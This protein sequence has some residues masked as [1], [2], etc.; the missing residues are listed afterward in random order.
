MKKQYKKLI[1][2]NNLLVILDFIKFCF[3]FIINY[4]ST[5]YLENKKLFVILFQ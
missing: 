1:Y 4:I 3:L 2:D 5:I